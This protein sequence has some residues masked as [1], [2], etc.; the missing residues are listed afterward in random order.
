MEFNTSYYWK[1]VAWD[2][3]GYSA[4]GPIWNFTTAENYPPY[5]PY[6]LKPCDENRVPI[7]TNLSWKGGDPAEWDIVYYSIY[8]E[9]GNPYPQYLA[10]IGPFNSTHAEILYDLSFDLE[11][12]KTYYWKVE[13]IDGLGLSSESDLCSFFTGVNSPPY[14]PLITGQKKGKAGEE[15]EYTFTAEDPEEDD[16]SYCIDWGDGNK[17]GWMGPYASG[18]TITLTHS[19]YPRNTYTITAQAK[20]HPYELPGPDSTF[21]V[22][23][24]K[25]HTMGLMNWLARFPFLQSLLEGLFCIINYL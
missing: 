12:F 21:V 18:Q 4:V 10:T 24:P 3:F 23:M 14:S 25:N 13:A 16:I 9:E 8:F 17:T 5:I 2:R 15:Y 6:D 7:D 19:W 20:D 22:T 11:I 1:I